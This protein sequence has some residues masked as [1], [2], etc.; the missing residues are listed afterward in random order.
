[1]PCH[2]VLQVVSTPGFA[3]VFAFF[4]VIPARISVMPNYIL[5]L[6]D[7]VTLSVLLW[8]VSNPPY[9]IRVSYFNF[10]RRGLKRVASCL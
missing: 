3:I 4:S 10:R 7:V 8:T 1:M 9:P 2:T 5:L 6:L